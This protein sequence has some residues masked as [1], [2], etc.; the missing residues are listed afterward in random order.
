MTPA[1]LKA[2]RAATGLTQKAL[3]ARLGVIR[4]TV[5]RW[6]TGAVPISKLHAT[7]YRCACEHQ[8]AD[9]K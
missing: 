9:A 3:A 5:A 2:L 6:E 1:D 7:A 8:A 4:V